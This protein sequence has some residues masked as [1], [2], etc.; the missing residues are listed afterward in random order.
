MSTKHITHARIF[1]QPAEVKQHIHRMAGE[2]VAAYPDASPVFIALLDGAMPFAAQLMG[3]IAEHDP[4]FHPI[5][6]TM[7]VSRYGGSRDGG[8][9][10]VVMDL[11]PKKVDLLPSSPVVLLDDLKDKGGTL[12]FTAQYLHKTY[13]VPSEN[14]ASAVLIERVPS[15][16]I[17]EPWPTE[18]VGMQYHGD[19]WLTGMGMDDVRI[20]IEGNRWAG[21]IG[22]AN[23]Q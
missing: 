19:E 8:E 16:P 7:T 11:S 23:G 15:A 3:A 5:L 20:G 12:R 6:A 13:G 14:I 4:Y 17:N 18:F 1:A 21:W 9:S 2:I 22:I 10:Q